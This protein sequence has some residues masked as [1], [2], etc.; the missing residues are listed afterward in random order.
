MTDYTINNLQS[1][2]VKESAV[3]SRAEGLRHCVEDG[4]PLLF[5]T[6]GYGS[7]DGG[8]TTLGSLANFIN[9]IDS[10]GNSACGILPG[11][12][13]L[14]D[15][16]GNGASGNSI[17]GLSGHSPVRL[18]RVQVSGNDVDVLRIINALELESLL[19]YPSGTGTDNSCILIVASGNEYGRIK[20]LDVILNTTTLKAKHALSF[21]G[22]TTLVNFTHFPNTLIKQ[23]TFNPGDTSLVRFALRRSDPVDPTSDETSTYRKVIFDDCIFFTDAGCDTVIQ[24]AK[25]NGAGIVTL[26]PVIFRNC[27]FTGGKNTFTL[28][29]AEWSGPGMEFY[30]CRFS[31]PVNGTTMVLPDNSAMINC[32]DP[33]GLIVL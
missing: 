25:V 17:F 19:I 29:S 14:G 7:G 26:E 15:Y 2:L 33:S 5:S 31:G 11:E 22:P 20:L 32:Y 21:G 10:Y 24:E 30:N 16:I 27:D 18:T 23:T 3:T 8:F 13:A 6:G 1:I 9:N 4:P 28:I 12:Y